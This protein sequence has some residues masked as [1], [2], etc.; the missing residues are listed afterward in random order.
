MEKA[1]INVIY[2]SVGSYCTATHG[3]I[4]ISLHDDL[5]FPKNVYYYY[6]CWYSIHIRMLT[7]G[8]AYQEAMIRLNEYTLAGGDELRNAVVRRYKN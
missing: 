3:T 5:H 8:A 1:N 6:S 2:L 4:Y 7:G